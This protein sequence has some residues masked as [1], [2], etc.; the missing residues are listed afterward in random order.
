MFWSAYPKKTA[1]PAALKTFKAAKIDSQLIST[2]LEDIESRKAG[3]DWQ[4]DGGKYIPNPATYL[5]Q[6]RWEDESDSPQPARSA[7]LARVI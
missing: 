1:K 4:K 7:I 2:I 5:N 3:D 6:R